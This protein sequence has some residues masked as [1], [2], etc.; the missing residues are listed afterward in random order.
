MNND[1]EKETIKKRNR[2]L[3]YSCTVLTYVPIE[4]RMAL[5][6][7]AKNKHVSMSSIIRRLIQE[8]VMSEL[9]V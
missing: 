6:V 3:N 1:L 4:L 9:S 5:N 7:I 2:K 8:Y